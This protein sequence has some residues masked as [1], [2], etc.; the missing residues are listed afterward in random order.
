LQCVTRKT[1]SRFSTI[2]P[3]VDHGTEE[4]AGPQ[5]EQ[6][7]GPEAGRWTGKGRTGQVGGH[8]HHTGLTRLSGLQGWGRSLDRASHTLL[9]R[10]IC[11]APKKNRTAGAKKVKDLKPT[12]DQVK[13]GDLKLLGEMLS[14]VS[15]TRSE[16]S[17][18]F[19]RNARA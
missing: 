9:I 18:T 8:H 16:I 3:G 14:N 15:K 11:M 4:V 10:E 19:A 12:V 6:G 17:K 5:A 13:G 2:L 1:V 7:E